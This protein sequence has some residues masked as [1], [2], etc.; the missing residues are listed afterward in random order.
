MSTGNSWL[1]QPERAVIVTDIRPR[2]VPGSEEYVKRWAE[3][4]RLSAIVTGGARGIG[5]GIASR[6]CRDG[7]AVTIVGRTKVPLDEAVEKL[8]AEGEAYSFAADVTKEMDVEGLLE[9]FAGRHERLDLLV[10]NAGIAHY[11]GLLKLDLADWR[12]VID[13]NLTGAFLMTQRAARRMRVTGGGSIV[14]IASIDSYGTDGRQAAYGAAKAALLNLTKTSAVE[15]ASHAIRVNSVS[16]GWTRTAMVEDH[17]S[18]EA[19][20]HLDGGFT[21]VPMRRLVE[22]DEVANA[23]AFLGGRD[24]S[25]ITGIDVPVDCGTLANLYI[26]ETLPRG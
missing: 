7:Y 21:R 26:M 11:K 16:P 12:S 2:N 1:Y 25:A 9:D 4:S 22:I 15:L 6:L 3:M 18:P 13:I 14:N 5:F 17:V 24:A 20:A 8:R 23:V 10:N 19:K